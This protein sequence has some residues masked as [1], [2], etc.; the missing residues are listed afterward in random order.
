MGP[1]MDMANLELNRLGHGNTCSALPAFMV[2]RKRRNHW[3]TH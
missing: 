1:L 3:G 2:S